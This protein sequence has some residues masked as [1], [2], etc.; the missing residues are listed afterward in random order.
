MSER[1][2]WDFFQCVE[3]SRKAKEAQQEAENAVK[4]AAAAYA[5]AERLYRVNLAQQIVKLIAEG[6]PATVARDLARGDRHVADLAYEMAVAEGVKE[7]MEQRAWRH[8]S[9]RKDVQNL[10]KWSMIVAPLGE[11]IER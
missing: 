2:A 11:Q 7:A 6:K 3:A 5:L 9:D 8:T 10:T 1:Q 4:D